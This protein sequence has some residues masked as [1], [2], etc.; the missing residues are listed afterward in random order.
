MQKY[1]GTFSTKNCNL[2]DD[3][4][5]EAAVVV[6]DVDTQSVARDWL[7]LLV[8][9]LDERVGQILSEH[10]HATVTFFICFILCIA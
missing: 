5:H 7:S 6:A 10:V 3:R 9:N 1:L 2:S 8:D 4:F